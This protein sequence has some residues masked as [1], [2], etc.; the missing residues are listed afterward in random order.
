MLSSIALSVL[1][2]QNLPSMN[3]AENI[4]GIPYLEDLWLRLTRRR[5][6]SRKNWL[7][8]KIV[9]EG[10]GLPLEESRQY[11]AH[12]QP[13]LCEFE[14][15]ILERND[16]R[17]E[18]LRIERLKATIER[19]PYSRELQSALRTIEAAEP[20][21]SADDLLFWEENGYV[22]LHDAI[23]REACRAT[24]LAVWDALQ[25]NPHEPE[26]WYQVS[27]HGI[28]R[29]FFHHPALRAN[30]RSER[31][32]KA[33]AQ[34]W[35]TA[36]LWMTVDRVSFNPPERDDWKFPGPGLHWD[37]TL[38][39]PVPFAVSGMIYLTDTES[40]QG[41]FTC[42]PGFH[43]HIDD[44]LQSLPAG[45]DP[46]CEDLES[47]GAVPISGRAGDLIIWHKA[48]PHGSRPNRTTRPRIVQYLSMHPAKHDPIPEWK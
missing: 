4:L 16:G 22:I 26:T 3:P 20:V 8:D 33:F 17:I 10:L 12:T 6:N 23:S 28:M 5:V 44:W 1:P 36:D 38:A 24:E 42:V 15:W 7:L 14:K 2:M 47:L 41:A 19:A 30:R 35:G 43:R 45:T 21:L 31:I 25:M 48:L 27:T 40:E 18:P 32:H 11:L 29:Q 13:T 9:L 39:P 34:I 37:T 46:R